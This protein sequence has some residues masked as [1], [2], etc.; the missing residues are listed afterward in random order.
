M[1]YTET[2]SRKT[3]YYKLTNTIQYFKLP[4][5]FED[6]IEILSIFGLKNCNI[7]SKSFNKFGDISLIKN[8]KKKEHI[9]RVFYCDYMFK[10]HF[11][12]KCLDFINVMTILR[13]FAFFIGY[14]LKYTTVI[15]LGHK[16]NIYS[17]YKIED[18]YKK[19][20]ISIKKNV[21]LVFD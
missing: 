11:D 10:H 15:G 14:G 17:L 7:T 6:T 8:V 21:W 20:T 5:T 3:H 19:S 18:E 1:V 16:Y 4:P 12:F 9:F 13:H 2:C